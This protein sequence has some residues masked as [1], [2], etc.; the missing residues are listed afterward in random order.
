MKER[1]D[2][3]TTSIDEFLRIVNRHEQELIVLRAQQVKARDT[4]VRKEIATEIDLAV[5]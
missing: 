1:F 2:S 3:I 4:L 5:G